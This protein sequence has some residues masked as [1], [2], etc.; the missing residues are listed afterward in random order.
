M[1]GRTAPSI[2]EATEI[3]LGFAFE[4]VYPHFAARITLVSRTHLRFHIFEGSH[5]GMTESVEYRAINLR[6]GLFVIAWQESMGTV[7]Q[8]DD[9]AERKVYG[10]VTL[11][12]EVSAFV[13]SSGTI[14]EVAT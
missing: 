9:F 7:V 12:G 6:P 4:V 2:A 1:V 3:P 11:S 14:R 13:G 10:H 8:I 5:A